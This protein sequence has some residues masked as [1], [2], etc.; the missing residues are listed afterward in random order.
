MRFSCR[1]ILAVV[2]LLAPT[3][4]GCR[5]VLQSIMNAVCPAGSSQ[6]P[7]ISD[8]VR[9]AREQEELLNDLN[10]APL[11]SESR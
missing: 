7:G 9:K 3:C 11:S 1:V 10:N 6:E 2:L 8:H 4:T 5:W